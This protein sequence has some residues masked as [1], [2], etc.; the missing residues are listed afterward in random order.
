MRVGIL[1]QWFDPEPGPARLPGALARSLAAR[2]HEVRVLTGF[3][4]YP[5]GVVKDGYSV[6]WRT[7]EDVDG[8][9]V[10]RVALYPS[11]DASP[12][13]R[14]ANYASFG[15]SA[16]AVGTSAFRGLDVVWVS[17]SPVT[18]GLPVWR[19][20]RAM[21]LPVLLHVL[22]LWPDNIVSSAL[23]R[24]RRTTQAL[25]SAVHA[26]NRWMYG[27]AAHVAGISPSIVGVLERRSV[28]REKL[29]YVPLWADE[30][31]FR[32]SEDETVR[33]ARGVPDDRVVVLYGGTLGRTQAIDLL[34][35]ACG[36]YPDD[37]PPVDV[38]VAGSGVEEDA[39]RDLAQRRR[40]GN[41]RVSFLGRI[42]PAAMSAVM[43]SA[44]LHYVGLRD[45][46][47]SAATMPSKL[48]A[49]MAC[50]K[51]ILLA[52]GGDAQ[53][54]VARA[55]AGFT[56]PP[57]DPEAVTSALVDAARLGRAGLRTRGRAARDAYERDFSLA[58]GTDRIERIL[59]DLR[60]R[61]SA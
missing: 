22:D 5:D 26:W 48:Q 12:V 18:V 10:R 2:G 1:S 17:N 58:S 54:V 43:A 13:R 57:G 59:D 15:V 55:G 38:W 60:T 20:S 56:V 42:P 49:T 51:P 44:D 53:G 36:R 32:P 34:I 11:H 24:S 3:P 40:T 7:D 52:I 46:P 14:A 37:A 35:D 19:L 4:N 23:V 30:E 61:R 33:R 16:A 21:R 41:A 6:R 25:A 27:N 9:A 47:N 50:A 39:L 29:S 8:V 45:D 28:P 31:S